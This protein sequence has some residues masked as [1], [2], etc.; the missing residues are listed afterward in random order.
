MD[1]L[2]LKGVDVTDC[3]E[4]NGLETVIRFNSENNTVEFQNTTDL[5][6][7]GKA[8]ELV[9]EEYLDNCY[10][11]IPTELYIDCCD[12]TFDNLIVDNIKAEVCLNEC[13]ATVPLISNNP[14]NIKYQCLQRQYWFTCEFINDVQGNFFF[15][16]SSQLGGLTRGVI[17]FSVK[18]IIQYYAEK[19]GLE[20]C[21][22]VIDGTPWECLY[23]IP[24]QLVAWDQNIFDSYPN[25]RCGPTQGGGS[26]LEIMNNQETVLQLLDRL[27]VTLC[28]DYV[29]KDCKLT[30]GTEAQINEIT[31]TVDIREGCTEDSICITTDT[32]NAC[33][34]FDGKFAQNVGQNDYS[35]YNNIVEWNPTANP[36]LSGACISSSELS[37]QFGDDGKL[38]IQDDAL[39]GTLAFDVL[40][41]LD[42]SRPI[43]DSKPE[44]VNGQWNGLMSFDDTNLPNL[45]DFYWADK[46]PG[47]ECKYLINDFCYTPNNFCESVKVL[48]E[49]G[50]NTGFITDQGIYKA[51]SL[52]GEIVIKWDSKQICV[53]TI[54]E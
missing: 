48:L 39:F 51:D 11:V 43:N 8:Y 22:P 14:D 53:R 47:I 29:I 25:I 15:V 40:L 30:W 44:F 23:I 7:V 2:K 42:K 20:W 9:K 49:N 32:S 5:R 38:N 24:N 27:N 50:L 6:L 1:R 18:E 19:C 54:I 33:A 46:R 3:V 17:G 4:L 26:I 28:A 12:L 10:G 13:E 52:T 45:Y 16:N 35:Y 31:G 36:H 37:A 21:T 41:T 34:Y